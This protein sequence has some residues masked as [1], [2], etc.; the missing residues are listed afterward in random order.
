[1]FGVLANLANLLEHG[2]EELIQHSGTRQRNAKDQQFVTRISNGYVSFKSKYDWLIARSLVTQD[3]WDVMEEIRRLRNIYVHAR[4]RARRLRH[5]Y[6]GFPLLS[7]RS[8]RRMF[9]EV[10]VVLRAMR[11]KA[12]KKRLKWAT[13]PPGYA[14]EQRWSA[15][16]VRALEI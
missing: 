4:P 3:Q 12:G 9:V 15:K 16:Y 2:C 8:I 6:R 5:N 7:Q 11:A 13:V 1:M 14:S 10:E